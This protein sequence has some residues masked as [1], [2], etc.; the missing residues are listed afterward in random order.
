ML[1]DVDVGGAFSE[2]YLN[3]GDDHIS[4]ASP[5]DYFL[6]VYGGRG[7]DVLRGIGSG[8]DNFSGD[9]GRDTLIGGGGD[10]ELLGGTGADR[11][12]GGRGNDRLDVGTGFDVF[13]FANKFGQDFFRFFNA[14]NGREDIDLSAVSAIRGDDLSQNHMEQM[15]DDVV[16]RG[17][18]NTITLDGVDISDLGNN[19]FIL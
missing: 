11:L 17:G 15:V 8:E 9:A 3:A 4:V 12:A 13:V 18:T 7:N 6:G 1:T 19:D 16:I 14:A 5:K 2:I 10:D